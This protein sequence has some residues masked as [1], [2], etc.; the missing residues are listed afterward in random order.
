ME[1]DDNALISIFKLEKRNWKHYF[2]GFAFLMIFLQLLT[3]LYIMFFYDPALGNAYKS[4]QH[5]SN[6]LFMGS[7][8]RNLHRWIPALLFIAIFIHTVRSL[9]RKDFQKAR[10]RVLWLTGTLFTLPLF[11]FL[12][13][14]LILPWEWKGYWF[15]EMIPNYFAFLPVVGPGMKAFFLESFTIPRYYVVH[16]VLL[17][18]ISVIL[19]DYHILRKLRQKGIFQYM[20]KHSIVALPFIILLFLL[21]VKIPIPSNAEE[22]P[23]MP[24]EGQWILAP[25]WFFLMILYPIMKVKGMMVPILS[26]GLPLLLFFGLAFMPYLFRGKKEEELPSDAPHERRHNNAFI[27]FWH[28]LNNTS[29]RRKVVHFVIVTS[30][31]LTFS[32]LLLFTHYESPTLGCNSCH[33]IYRGMRMGDPP[34]TFKDRNKNPVLEDND[35]MMNHWY[36]PNEIW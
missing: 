36:Y 27:R 4:V 24:L 34:E 20:F 15:M 11:L 28:N 13:T 25:E 8:T 9:L 19:L 17:P 22:M 7:L 32:G 18:L 31:T 29:F 30:I 6:K 14:G 26:V 23:P 21:A 3:G 35:W 1:K 12:V 16:V 5:I 33:N 10:M 2:G